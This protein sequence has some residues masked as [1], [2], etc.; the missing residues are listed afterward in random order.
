V[1]LVVM[2]PHGGLVDVRL[3]RGVV[4]RKSWY[5]V[6]HAS[7]SLVSLRVGLA[8]YALRAAAVRR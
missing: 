7:L 1:V 2:D 4:V 6:R 8:L 3:E 5:L